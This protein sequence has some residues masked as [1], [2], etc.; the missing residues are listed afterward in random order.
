MVA[1][2]AT[3][4]PAQVARLTAF[5]PGKADPGRLIHSRDP[6]ARAHGSLADV[7]PPDGQHADARGPRRVG[8]G[9]VDHEFSICQAGV[10]L[11]ASGFLKQEEGCLARVPG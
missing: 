10:W 7:T 11:R 5:A 6:Q 3:S 2:K 1:A 9:G 8:A 4:A